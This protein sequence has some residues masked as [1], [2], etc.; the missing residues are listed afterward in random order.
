MSEERI[1]QLE[2]AVKHLI[3]SKQEEEVLADHQDREMTLEEFHNKDQEHKS[4]WER[5]LSWI[6][7]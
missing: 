7:E 2:D 6:E 3:L 5:F 1:S 4:V